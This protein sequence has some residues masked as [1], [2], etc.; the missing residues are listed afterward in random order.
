MPSSTSSIKW[1]I[2]GV[3]KADGHEG[4]HPGVLFIEDDKLYLKVFFEISDP[5]QAARQT[6]GNSSKF[7]PFSGTE[8]ADRIR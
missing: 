8:P 3:W 7:R 6:A 4:S 1:P 2:I 5:L